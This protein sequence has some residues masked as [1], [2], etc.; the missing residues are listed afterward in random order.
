MEVLLREAVF[1]LGNRGDVVKVAAGYARNYLFPKRIAIPVTEGN[2]R[3][4]EYEKRSYERKQLAEKSVAEEAK[5]A[6]EALSLV[7][8]KRAGETNQLF[9]SVTSQ[10]VAQ[11][12][13]EKGFDVDRRKLDVP[14]IKEIGEY[15]AL[16]HLH[17]DVNAE[18]TLQ[19]SP[20]K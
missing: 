9:G 19:V 20:L 13:K 12:L 15:K 3:Q 16:V 18:I 2:K 7:F 14:H 10:E 11:T 4:L 5:T 6:L 8:H 17:S 1:K